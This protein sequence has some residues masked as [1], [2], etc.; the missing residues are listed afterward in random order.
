M[1]KLKIHPE[2][3]F[4]IGENGM[5]KSTLIEAIAVASGFNAEGGSKNFNF[6]TRASHSSL[7]QYIRT[8]RGVK[9]H[10]DGFFLRSESFFNVATQ[11]EKLDEDETENN[12]PK[13]MD[14]YGGVSL[15]EL[16]HGESFWALFVNRFGGNGFY[17]LDEPE[18]ALSPSR[19]LAMLYKIHQLIASGSQFIIATHSPILIAY[20]NALVYELGPNGLQARNYKDTELFKTYADF[21]KDSDGHVRQLLKDETNFD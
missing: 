2:V 9:R 3:T 17:I 13:I 14:S 18:S 21:M 4:F 12:L 5:G 8:V 15:H 10:T 11:I 19:Q 20:P 16:S 7:H 1:D 6:G